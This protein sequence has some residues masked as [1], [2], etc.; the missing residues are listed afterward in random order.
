MIEIHD[1]LRGFI[2]ESID[3]KYIGLVQN[4]LASVNGFTGGADIYLM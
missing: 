2:Q 4:T 1:G 3:L